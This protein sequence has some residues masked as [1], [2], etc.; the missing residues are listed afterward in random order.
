MEYKDY[1]NVL[2]VEKKA[3]QEEIKKAYRKL[4]VKYHPD[5]NKG[6]QQAE[7]RFKEIAEAYEVLKDPE[8]RKKYD[9]LGANW[10]QYQQQGGDFGGYDYSRWGSGG[11]RRV[12][13]EGDVHDFF[14]GSGFSD[15]FESF[16]GRADFGRARGTNRA[17]FKGHDLEAEMAISLKEAFQGTERLISVNGQKLRIKIKP[18]VKDQQVLKIRQKGGQGVGGGQSGDL[19]LKIIVNDHPGIERKDQDLYQDVSVDL[20]LAML[21]GELTLETLKGNMKITIPSE[22]ENGKVLRLKGLGMP[23]YGKPGQKGDLYVRIRVNL[24]Q[25]L[26]EEEKK[27]FRKLASLR[28]EKSFA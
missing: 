16:F 12:E 17:G 9:T 4:A 22:T 2:G 19:Y 1:Y 15:F 20:Y 7:E 8:K 18:G 6:D 13:F 11:G 27:L 28:K 14:G 3:T 23:L 25:N 24:P 21:G 26:N 5:K 10:K